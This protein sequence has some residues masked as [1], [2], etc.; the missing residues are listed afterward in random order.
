M[1]NLVL[2]CSLLQA[3]GIRL[4][5]FSLESA[6]YSF[7]IEIEGQDSDPTTESLIQR[8][9]EVVA[10]EA[11][12][13]AVPQIVKVY[14]VFHPP[15]DIQRQQRR[16]QQC[17]IFETADDRHIQPLYTD[18]LVLVDVV[19]SSSLEGV[20]RRKVSWLRSSLT[21]TTLLHLLYSFELCENDD[22]VECR[23]WNNF[24]EWVEPTRIHR[25]NNGDYVL[26]HIQI[27]EDLTVSGCLEHSLHFER[28]ERHRRVYDESPRHN[29]T[30][31]SED[32]REDAP[33]PIC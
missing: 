11:G 17:Y 15:M 21:R 27:T 32:Y 22:A 7:S 29:G 12:R 6:Y 8:F 1:R 28:S 19:I 31:D 3:V 14:R 5:I 25:L 23:V 24:D 18:V 30:D 2:I 16:G 33:M 13:L 26:L 10:E 20:R 9:S 4:H